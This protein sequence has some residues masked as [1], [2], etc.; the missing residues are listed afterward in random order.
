MTY[1]APDTPTTPDQDSERGKSLYDQDFQQWIEQTVQ[2]LRDRSYGS[3]DWENVIEELDTLGRSERREVGSRL[4]LILIHLLKWQYQPEQRVYSGHIWMST[5]DEQRDE[6][7]AILADSPSLKSYLLEVFAE[8]Y[9]TAR[10]RAARQTG[11]AIATFPEASPF[12][13]EAALDP[14]FLP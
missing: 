14:D 10:R 5:I 8:K 1:S 13:P 7:Q 12:T 4:T 3:V 2:Q 6:L 11:L 9:A